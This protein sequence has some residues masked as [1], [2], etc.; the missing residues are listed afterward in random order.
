MSG[1]RWTGLRRVFRLPVTRQRIGDEVN[2][3]LRFHIEERI[4]ELMAR[5]MTRLQA[6]REERERFGDLESYRQQ[7]RAVDEH[8]A[9][10]ERRMEF[11]DSLGREVRQAVRA[12]ARSR[13]FS[14]IALVTL[15]LGIGATTAIFTLLDAVVL[16]PLPYTDA[17]RLVNVASSVSGATAAGSWRVSP[18]GYFYYRQHNHSFEDLGAYR[19]DEATLT[20]SEGAQRV[21]TVGVTASLVHVLRLRPALGRLLTADDDRPEA[22]PAMVLSHGFWLRRF[23]GDPHVIGRTI[24]VDA[25]PTEVVGVLP[26]GAEI[27]EFKA[28]LWRAMRLDPAAKPQNEHY[29]KVIGRL[30]GGVTVTSAT[31]DLASLT[32]RFPEVMPS[33]YSPGFMR[34]YHFAVVATPLRD[35]VVGDIARTLW[36]LFASVAL[37]LLMACANVANLF[38]VR[39]EAR[40]REVAIRAALGAGRAHLAWHFLAESVLLLLAAGAVGLALSY[41]ALRT[42]LVLAPS[43]IPRL[44]EV[45]LGWSAVAFAAGISLVAGM[46]FGLIPLSRGDAAVATLRESGRGLSASR[47]QHLVRGALVVGQVALALM[48][49]VAAGLMLQSF[50]NLRHVRP[51]FDPDG[52]LAVT[53]AVPEARYPSYET[54][55]AFHRAFA[56]RLGALAGVQSVG[57]TTSLPLGNTYGV[58]CSLVYVEGKPVPPKQEPPCLPVPTVAPGYFQALGIPVHGNAPGWSDVEQ[59]A[60]GVV[61][62]RAF[63]ERFWPGEDPIGKGVKGG[64]DAPPYYRVVG[65]AENVRANGLD[66]P[67]TEAVYYPMIPI[68]GAGMWGPQRQMTFVIKAR[69]A[70]PELLTVAIRRTLAELDPNVPIADVQTM[71]SV[72]AKSMAR[73]SFTM[74][75]LGVAGGMALVLSAVGIYGVISYLVGQRRSEIGIRMALGA[76]AGQVGGLVVIQSVR[77]A[78]IGVVLGLAAALAA[79]RLLR[80]LLFEVSPTDPVTMGAVAALLIVIAATASYAPARRAAGV[81]PAEALRAE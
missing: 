40:R 77:L 16:R 30:E 56:T 28:D 22:A 43:S 34:E 9:R 17:G 7:M 63:A 54:V 62:S 69:T 11:F 10:E 50:R 78:V 35:V 59:H 81:D 6:E 18:G 14:V 27:P 70:R 42:L 45:H 1:E 24:S 31:A 76:R 32:S 33:A 57:A 53:V 73:T 51:G 39:A 41:A 49:L 5:G 67:P 26:A 13:A 79:T 25:E 55:A 19:L 64:G 37:V 15:A 47:R 65:V 23:G 46:V 68:P 38:L 60:A 66:Q 21:P 52:V 8:I 12:L 2:A 20:G 48:L 36:I 74:L 75:L 4:E 3:E 72:V 29:L 80:S 71:E 61:V 58:G 44:S